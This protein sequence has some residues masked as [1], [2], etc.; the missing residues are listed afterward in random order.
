MLKGAEVFPN[1]GCDGKADTCFKYKGGIYEIDVKLARLLNNGCGVYSWGSTKV[2][3]VKPPVYPLI[4]VPATGVDMSGWYCKWVG[5]RT[6]RNPPPH[7][8]P[9]LENFWD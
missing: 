4:V 7:C 2:Y 5:L 6:G 9:G 8:P 3:L 1:A